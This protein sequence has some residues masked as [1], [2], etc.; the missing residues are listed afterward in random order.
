MLC[1]PILVSGNGTVI[2]TRKNCPNMMSVLSES[3][4]FNKSLVHA[5][6]EVL[7]GDGSVSN[8]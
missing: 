6:T 1:S 3:R 7:I 4:K 2:S 8:T 5:S